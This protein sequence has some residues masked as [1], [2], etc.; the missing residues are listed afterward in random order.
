MSVGGFVTRRLGQLTV[1]GR[2]TPA[3]Y[4]AMAWSERLQGCHAVAGKAE[5]F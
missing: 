2:R 3:N 5:D 1:E 4:S